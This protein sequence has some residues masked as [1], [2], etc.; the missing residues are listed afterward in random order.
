MDWGG[1][2]I[3]QDGLLAP[4]LIQSIKPIL[5]DTTCTTRVHL[6]TQTI[7]SINT[8]LLQLLLPAF[9]VTDAN[10]ALHHLIHTLPEL[11]ITTVLMRN[12]QCICC[13]PAQDL[14]LT[15]HELVDIGDTVSICR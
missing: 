2:C 15:H 3:S 11:F 4:T 5:A 10:C 8:Y 7:D 13:L 14:H 6:Q 12:T 1:E 9:T